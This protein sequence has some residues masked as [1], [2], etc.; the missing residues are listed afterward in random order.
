MIMLVP[1]L[2]PLATGEPTAQTE[3]VVSS[4]ARDGI[5]SSWRSSDIIGTNVKTSN[6]DTIGEIEDFIVDLNS[7]EILGVV[8]ATGGF[9]GIADT[10]TSVPTSALRYD[11]RTEAFKTKL[12][13]EQLEKAPQYKKD[14]WQAAKQNMG[15]QLR[16][17]RD[18]MDVDTSAPDNAARNENDKGLTPMDQGSSEADINRTQAIRKALM[19]TD[20]SM[21]AKNV[22]VITRDG[23]VTLRGVVD[24]DAEHAAVVAL[25]KKHAD[26][27]AI[28]D[29]LEVKTKD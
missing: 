8:I 19:D 18:S 21:N 9:L 15:E 10:L 20:H 27:S 29:Q 24:S 23:K 14:T 6:D 28:N 12:T 4:T 22:K 11:V 7:G 17:Y 13:K 1:L 3:K 25:A 26:A 5:T 2:A 16:S